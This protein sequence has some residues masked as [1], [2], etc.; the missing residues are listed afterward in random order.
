MRELIYLFIL[1]AIL[2]V[3]TILFCFADSRRL[4][5]K[6]TSILSFV[7][8]VILFVFGGLASVFLPLKPTDSSYITTAYLF[9]GVGIFL[10][11]LSG[12]IA[13]YLAKTKK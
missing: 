13:L 2:Y 10:L 3:I 8:G 11:V 12:G 7:Y 5:L 1:F 6:V 4:G 9:V